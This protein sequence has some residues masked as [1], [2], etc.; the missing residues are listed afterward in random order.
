MN[1]ITREAIQRQNSFSKI[2]SFVTQKYCV[3]KYYCLTCVTPYF[4][5]YSPYYSLLP[6]TNINCG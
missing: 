6:M 1:N 4:T 5:V 3:Y 2:K